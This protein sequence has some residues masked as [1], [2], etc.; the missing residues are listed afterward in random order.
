VFSHS[1]TCLFD[2]SK[3]SFALLNN[4]WKKQK[5][6]LW[7]ILLLASRYTKNQSCRSDIWA[8]DTEDVSTGR[9]LTRSEKKH[10]GL[11]FFSNHLCLDRQLGPTLHLP[12]FISLLTDSPVFFCGS[13]VSGTADDHVLRFPPPQ[14]RWWILNKD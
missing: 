6:F 8:F 13:K 14:T 12:S 4:K 9:F 1:Q 5:R 2:G 7:T 10:Q 11:F 3:R